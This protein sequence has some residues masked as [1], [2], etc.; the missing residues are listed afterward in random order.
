MLDGSC[1]SAAA[2]FGTADAQDPQPCR[3]KVEHLADCLTDHMKRTAA[4]RAKPALDVECH[5]LARQ[6]VGKRLSPRRWFET[7]RDRLRLSDKR[8][9]PRDIGVEVFEP[10]SK[11]ILSS[12]SDRRPNCVRCRRWM[13]SRSRFDLGPRLRK[14]RVRRPT[15]CAASSR[16]NRCSASTSA[17]SAVRS[18]FT[19]ENLT[20]VS[21]NTHRRLSS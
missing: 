17:G 4:A 9:R 5:V 6:I 13:M 2:I 18:R 14:L 8:L 12:R 20:P 15:T 21:S 11:L 3:H 10:Q 7:R 16:T 19:L 1:R